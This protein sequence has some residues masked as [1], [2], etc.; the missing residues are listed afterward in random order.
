MI[1]QCISSYYTCDEIDIQSDHLPLFV[2]IDIEVKCADPVINP[3]SNV[4]LPRQQWDRS[5]IIKCTQKEYLDHLLL[6]LE[7]PMDCINCTDYLCTDYSH[8][9]GIQSFHYSL[10]ASCIEASK[11]MIVVRAY[12]G[13]YDMGDRLRHGILL[14]L[15]PRVYLNY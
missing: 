15:V 6:L 12:E 4:R 9:I 2:T 1:F 8:I 14:S 13:A 3:T 5:S 11:V 10:I 7:I